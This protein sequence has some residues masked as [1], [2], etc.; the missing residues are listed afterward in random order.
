[1]LAVL[2]LSWCFSWKRSLFVNRELVAVAVGELHTPLSRPYSWVTRIVYG[3]TR[4]PSNDIDLFEF[5]RVGQ[6]A[7]DASGEDLDGLD[8]GV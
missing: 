2:L 3:S 6:V 7:V 4:T 5:D 8:G 1:M